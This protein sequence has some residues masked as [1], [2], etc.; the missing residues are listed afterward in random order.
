MELQVKKYHSKIPLIVGYKFESTAM[1]SRF[2]TYLDNTARVQQLIELPN[3][4]GTIESLQNDADR[5]SK[6]SQRMLQLRVLNDN[7]FKGSPAG[8]IVWNSV[9][10]LVRHNELAVEM[11]KD[12]QLADKTVFDF[13]VSIGK[14]P[15]QIDRVYR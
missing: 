11:F 10:E 2:G 15:L 1:N 14:D 4:G 7:I 8:L 13:F 5:L 3:A 9:G 6:Q 12:M